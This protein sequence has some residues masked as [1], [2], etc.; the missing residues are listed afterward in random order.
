[1][2]LWTK[3]RR[4][5]AWMCSVLTA[6]RYIVSTCV[7]L[8]VCVCVRVTLIIMS[9]WVFSQIEWKKNEH[10]VYLQHFDI[11]N[12]AR[13]YIFMYLSCIVFFAA[14]FRVAF[15][16]V[17]VVSSKYYYTRTHTVFFFCSSHLRVQRVAN[18]WKKK[19]RYNTK[20]TLWMR[21]FYPRSGCLRRQH[22]CHY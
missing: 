12:D 19:F 2:S 13:L 17:L 6:Q 10:N 14:L 5:R 16:A 7:C 4:A 8:W 15:A 20:L 1:M 22:I 21:I 9:S 18:W 3:S 11:F